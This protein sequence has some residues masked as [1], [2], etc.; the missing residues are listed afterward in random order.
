MHD[1]KTTKRLQKLTRPK[2]T[3]G[4][5]TTEEYH[6]LIRNECEDFYLHNVEI[7]LVEKS[8]LTNSDA[9]KASGID[10]ICAKFL[11]NCV[12]LMLSMCQ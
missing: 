5:K 12:P 4:I 3:F 11:K 1:Q 8:F 2:N 9:T 6:K 10:Q 7:T